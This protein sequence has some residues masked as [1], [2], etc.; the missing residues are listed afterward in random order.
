MVSLDADLCA[1]RVVAAA[2]GVPDCAPAAAAGVRFGREA[3]AGCD[4]VERPP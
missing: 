2:L 1:V 4:A 3:A